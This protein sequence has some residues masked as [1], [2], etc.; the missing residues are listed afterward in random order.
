M[1]VVI[2]AAGKGTRMKSDLPKV[3]HAING[4][5]MINRVIDA[6]IS[7]FFS[8]IIVVIGHQWEKVKSEVENAFSG[9]VS[10]AIQHELRGTGDAVRSALPVLKEKIE[11]VLILCGD[12]PLIQTKTLQ[13]FASAHIH[14]GRD[15]SVFSVC[16]EDPTGYGRVLLDENQNFV[17]IREEVDASLEEKSIQMVNSGIYCV[18][19]A[20]LMDALELIRSDNA[21]NEYYLT[22]IITIARKMGAVAGIYTGDAPDECIGVN[23]LEELN[24]VENLMNLRER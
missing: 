1:A 6:V 17:A 7:S 13:L 3:L 14:D 16:V 18:K 12:V 20:F 15:I 11:H 4:R 9:K 2:L 24:L 5:S 21:Q 23:T 10:Y 19:K 8:N 22:D